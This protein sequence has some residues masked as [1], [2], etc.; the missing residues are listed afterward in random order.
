MAN[1]TDVLSS[2]DRKAV[3]MHTHTPARK[4]G[5]KSKSTS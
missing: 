2:V 3:E 5:R 1:R 4:R